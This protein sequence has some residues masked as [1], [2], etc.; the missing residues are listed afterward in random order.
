[1]WETLRNKKNIIS[2]I[3]GDKQLSDE[4]IIEIMTDKL[5]NEDYG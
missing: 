3:M 2:T 1:M 4:E 5:I